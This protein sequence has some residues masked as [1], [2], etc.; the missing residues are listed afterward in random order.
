[1]F[2]A[3]R[4]SGGVGILQFGQPVYEEWSI[5][6]HVSSLAQICAMSDEKLKSILMSGERKKS[7]ER[8]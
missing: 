3:M 5:V 6:I 1:M 4:Q 8:L 7:S 2:P